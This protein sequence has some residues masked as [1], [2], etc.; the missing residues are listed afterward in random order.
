MGCEKMGNGDG[1]EDSSCK[2]CS[3]CL[4]GRRRQDGR[5]TGWGV[6]R[7]GR[8]TLAKGHPVNPVHPVC[9]E[10]VDRMAGGQDGVGKGGEGRRWRGGI[11]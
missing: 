9:G 7:W 10:E 2:S 5:M 4:R 3:S 6:R 1:G 8:E 11:L